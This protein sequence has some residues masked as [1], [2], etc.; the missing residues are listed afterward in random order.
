MRPG[1]A[2][3]FRRPVRRYFLE[4]GYGVTSTWIS[5]NIESLRSKADIDDAEEVVKDRLKHAELLYNLLSEEFKDTIASS[6]D[7]MKKGVMTYDLLWTAFQPGCL[8]YTKV[9][10]QDRILRLYGSQYG[11]DRNQNPVFWLT[12]QYIDYDGTRFGTNKLNLSIMSYDG[13]KAFSTLAALPLEHHAQQDAMRKKLTERGAQMEALA[14]SHYR[15]YNGVGYRLNHMNQTEKY[16]IK[17]RI[18]IDT[19]GWNRFNPNQSVFVTPLYLK[20]SPTATGFSASNGDAKDG[21]G[22]DGYDEYDGGGQ[23]NDEDCHFPLDGFFVEDD[24]EDNKIMLTEQQKMLCCPSLR[25]YAL[26]EKM[27]LNFVVGAVSD[28]SFNTKAF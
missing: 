20:D 23:D 19:F 1:G 3:F 15:S 22:A 27:W 18:M 28:V 10:G 14:G 25:G 4:Q 8:V 5:E 9:Q 16:S 26:K 6:Q 11:R 2:V 21:A 13:T 12:L 24:D 7:L 17:G